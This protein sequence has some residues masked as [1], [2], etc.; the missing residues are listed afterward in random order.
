[1]K[2]RDFGEMVAYF[3][4]RVADMDIAQKYKMELLGMITAIEMKHDELVPK[5]IPISEQR[6]P[7]DMDRTLVTI[8]CRGR[9]NVRSGH[10]FKGYFMND[11][12]DTWKVDDPEVIAWM[13]LPEPWKGE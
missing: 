6:L 7:E 5:W 3:N 4:R 9:Q 1:M 13:P 2:K 12:G 10:F 8:D 11:N